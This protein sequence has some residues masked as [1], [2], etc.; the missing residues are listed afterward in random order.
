MG[1]GDD[2]KLLQE[3]GLDLEAPETGCCGLAGSFGYERQ[4]Y[5]V[6]MK[7][8]EH[9]LLPAVRQAAKDELV[10]ADGF[11][12]RCQIE[13]GSDRRAMHLAEVLQLALHEGGAAPH[14]YPEA[15][16]VQDR[17]AP[18]SKAAAVAALAGGALAAGALGW[19]A[20]RRLSRR[21]A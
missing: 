20:W 6:S 18:P 15:G 19:L 13:H 3:A 7:V 4:H 9:A 8:G 12:C 5:D 21:E 10:I 1:M 2:E 17:P 14:P 11:S 16:H